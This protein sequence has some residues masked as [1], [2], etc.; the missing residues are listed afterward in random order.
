MINYM[1]T[2][3]ID[4]LGAVIALSMALGL[5]VGIELGRRCK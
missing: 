1:L 3:Q 5:V 4:P 2:H